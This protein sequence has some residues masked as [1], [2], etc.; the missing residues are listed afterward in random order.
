[1]PYRMARRM[2]NYTFLQ[3]TAIS[4]DLLND[5]CASFLV[6]VTWVSF[7]V[8]VQLYYSLA[9]LVPHTPCVGAHSSWKLNSNY[10]DLPA[11]GSIIPQCWSLLCICCTVN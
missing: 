6:L 4:T 8:P 9:W 10:Y 1:M 2:A 7:H 11:D 3:H 5:R